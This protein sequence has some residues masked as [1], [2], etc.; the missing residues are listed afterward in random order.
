MSIFSILN[1]VVWGICVVIAVLIMTD[2]I[3]TEKSRSKEE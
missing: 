3:K 1:Y 2:F